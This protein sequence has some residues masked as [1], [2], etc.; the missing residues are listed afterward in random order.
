M[1]AMAC[2]QCNLR[3]APCPQQGCSSPTATAST[4]ARSSTLPAP[5]PRARWPLP[6][7]PPWRPSTPWTAATATPLAP[8][9]PACARPPWSGE[10]RAQLCGGCAE[11]AAQQARRERNGALRPPPGEASTPRPKGRL[12]A[13]PPHSLPGTSPPSLHHRAAGARARTTWWPTL[14]GWTCTPL[15]ALAWRCRR[16]AAPSR[17]LAKRARWVR[18]R[19]CP[20]PLP[21]HLSEQPAVCSRCWGTPST[22]LPQ[23]NL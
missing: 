15:P 3:L 23:A 21:S 9:R 14:R 8:P 20:P 19:R 22:P 13:H 18:C 10:P 12:P 4:T 7:P 17:Q 11:P 2:L 5:G 6:P 1:S 16:R